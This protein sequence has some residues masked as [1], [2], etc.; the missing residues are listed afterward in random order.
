[1]AYHIYPWH[2]ISY[3]YAG[4]RGPASRARV[5]GQGR[6]SRARAADERGHAAAGADRRAG[7]RAGRDRPGWATVAQGAGRAARG[8][9]GTPEPAGGPAGRGG[10][11]GPARGGQ[12]PPPGRALAV[13]ARAR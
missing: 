4:T 3:E 2:V 8:G 6:Q 9:G 10:P 1:M 13:K 5:D 7:R 11:G 12:G